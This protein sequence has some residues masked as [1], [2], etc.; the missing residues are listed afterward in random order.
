MFE[1]A[2]S[3][4]DYRTSDSFVYLEYIIRIHKQYPVYRRLSLINK[5]KSPK[6]SECYE[7]FL[8]TLKF[9]QIRYV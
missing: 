9:P 8:Q 6:Q 1:R 4:N 7:R 5:F 3:L 2:T